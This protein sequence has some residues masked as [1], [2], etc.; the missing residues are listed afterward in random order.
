MALKKEEQEML[1][2]GG[3]ALLLYLSKRKAE[4]GLGLTYAIEP[5]YSEGQTVTRRKTGEHNG[6]FRI[7]PIL[8]IRP[9]VPGEFKI[10]WNNRNRIVGVKDPTYYNSNVQTQYYEEAVPQDVP[11]GQIKGIYLLDTKSPTDMF[12]DGLTT[13]ENPAPD[14]W[15]HIT[16]GD[17]IALGIQNGNYYTFEISVAA[18][19]ESP[20]GVVKAI[21][22]KFSEEFKSVSALE[23][24]LA[25]G[26]E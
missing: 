24:A 14:G 12:I 26:V 15:L 25:F 3:A 11:M 2:I 7:A 8:T 18:S 13:W 22:R 23:L 9:D 4:P 21:T 16:D 20:T 6:G 1:L 10:Q 5:E 17:F 19:V